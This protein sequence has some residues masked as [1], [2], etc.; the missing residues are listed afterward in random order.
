MS[1]EPAYCGF[2]GGVIQSDGAMQLWTEGGRLKGLILVANG[3][4]VRHVCRS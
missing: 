4:T 1:T 3:Q 2:C